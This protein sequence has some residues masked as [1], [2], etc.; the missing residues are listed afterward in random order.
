[1]IPLE[2]QYMLFESLLIK[3]IPQVYVIVPPAFPELSFD[4]L[5]DALVQF[6]CQKYPCVYIPGLPRDLMEMFLYIPYFIASGPC[7]RSLVFPHRAYTIH[8]NLLKN[9]R[10]LRRNQNIGV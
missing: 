4:F 1:M 9:I 10:A 2:A 8:G 7:S 6:R 5:K 3:L